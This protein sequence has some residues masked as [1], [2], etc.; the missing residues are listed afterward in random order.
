MS[1][2]ASATFSN[3]EPLESCEHKYLTRCLGVRVSGSYL[4]Q[5]F[6]PPRP[7]VE[8]E[9]ETITVN[10][11]TSIRLAVDPAEWKAQ[12]KECTR[13]VIRDIES[14]IAELTDH[15]KRLKQSLFNPEIH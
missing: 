8:I 1:R 11:C 7:V 5:G 14:L 6:T 9:R 13:L 2:F 3:A 12:A 4:H 10:T 15:R